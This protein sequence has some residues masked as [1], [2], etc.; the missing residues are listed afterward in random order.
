MIG[1]RIFVTNSRLS[2]RNAVFTSQV[3]LRDL[4]HVRRYDGAQRSDAHALQGSPGVQHPHGIRH[5]EQY[6]A[7][8]YEH[9]VCYHGVTAAQ[10]VHHLAGGNRADQ[11]PDSQYG[12]N[13]RQLFRIDIEL[14]RAV[15]HQ[16]LFGRRR[17]SQYRADGH[18]TDGS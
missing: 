16:H 1:G 10:H 7:D 13:S 15:R 5:C 9:R 4:S 17:P 2:F 12:A 6:P 8:D 18:R 3:R 11:C 14:D